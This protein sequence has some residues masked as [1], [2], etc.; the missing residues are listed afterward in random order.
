VAQSPPVDFPKNSR[1]ELHLGRRSAHN[2][3]IL[4][5]LLQDLFHFVQSRGDT[6]TLVEHLLTGFGEKDLFA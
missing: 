6:P 3:D 4:F 5:I 2:H 1:I